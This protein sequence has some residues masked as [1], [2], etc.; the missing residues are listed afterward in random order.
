MVKLLDRFGFT[1]LLTVC[2]LVLSV[3]PF[4]Q[5]AQSHDSQRLIS[6]VLVAAALLV[7]LCFA[8]VSVRSIWIVAAGYICGLLAVYMSP[9]PLWS[10]LEFG[11]LFSVALLGLTLIPKLSGLQS[12]HLLYIFVIIQTFYVVHNLTDYAVVMITGAKLEPYS[13]C[14]GFS[15][16]RFYG[17]FLTWTMPFTIGALAVNKHYPYRKAIAFLLLIEW[18]FEFLTLNRS[19]IV[20]MAAT[21]PAVWW[22]NRPQFNAYANWLLLSAGGGF[23]IYILMLHVVPGLLGIDVSYAVKFS[24]GRD[25]LDSSGRVQLWL[26]SAHLMMS[27]PWLGAGP[28]MTALDS[29]SKIASHPHNYILQLLAEWGV[30]FT[31]LLVVGATYG[32]IQWKKL[33]NKTSIEIQLLALPVTAALAAGA[34]AGLF[35]GLLVMPVS[36]TYMTLILASCAGIWRALTPNV[37]RRRF[38]WWAIPILILPAI[39]TAVF[40]VNNWPRWLPNTTMTETMSGDGFKLQAELLPRFWSTGKIVITNKP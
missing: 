22:V 12:K 16:T 28:M 3:W 24:S 1:V 18:G 4:E 40:A 8:Q 31:L 10:M 38:P 39:F 2:L 11:L 15:N 25:V 33:I 36:L 32:A 19:F 6:T 27:H 30:P 29:T 5:Y 23:A 20:A 14:N 26:D 37:H 13:L 21:L 35:D 17:Q 9:L 34:V 7:S